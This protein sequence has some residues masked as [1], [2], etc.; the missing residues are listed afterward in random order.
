MFFNLAPEIILF[1]PVPI[2]DVL[3]QLVENVFLVDLWSVFCVKRN[4]ETKWE[5]V[6]IGFV[7]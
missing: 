7:G 1:G 6:Y 4:K 3:H 2:L 5:G